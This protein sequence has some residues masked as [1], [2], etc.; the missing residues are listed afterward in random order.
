M[1]RPFYAFQKVLFSTKVK[2]SGLKK[3]LETYGFAWSRSFLW[4]LEVV[5]LHI[6]VGNDHDISI[7]DLSLLISKIIGFKGEIRFD[8][9]MPDG[10]M[11]KL[12]D[13]SLIKSTGWLPSISIESGIKFAYK[14]FIN[15]HR[16]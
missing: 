2:D 1:Y 13:S 7:K 10:T 6:N 15:S 3:R 14:D 12:L 4:R 8:K 16:K 11:R 9:T 5:L